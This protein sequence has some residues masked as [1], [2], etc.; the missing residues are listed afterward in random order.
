MHE[1]QQRVIFGLNRRHDMLHLFRWSLL[2]RRRNKLHLVYRGNI[3]R[4]YGIGKLHE[5]FSRN[6]SNEHGPSKLHVMLSGHFT[7]ERR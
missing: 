5:L 2:L 6:I 4:I 7:S 1:L 3:F